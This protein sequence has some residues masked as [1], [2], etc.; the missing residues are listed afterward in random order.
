M[1]NP[2][3]EFKY[4]LPKNVRRMIN[5][6]LWGIEEPAEF[7]KDIPF[8]HFY[9]QKGRSPES[10]VEKEFDPLLRR[11][12]D[13]I[14]SENSDSQSLGE[15]LLAM[16]DYFSAHDYNR[17]MKSRAV[18][19]TFKER[20]ESYSAQVA[21]RPG[22]HPVQELPT[23]FDVTESLRWL[24]R[25]LIILNVPV[26]RTA[27]THSTAAAFCGIPC[28]IAK[29]RHKTPMVLTEH[30]VYM[31]EQNLFLSRF[32]SLL[33]SKRFLLNL[34]NAVSRANYWFADVV[35]PVCRYN[36]RWELAH[37]TDPAKI[38]VIYNGVDAAT[39]SPAPRPAGP[40]HVIATARIDP[41]KD[42]ETF[43]RVAATV[44][45]S[46]PTVR[47]TI[48]GSIADREY[49]EKCLRLRSELRLDDVVA[50]GSHTSDVVSAY[51]ESDIVAL[52]SVSEAFPYSVIE[53]MACGKPVIAS[54]VGGVR[55]ALDEGGI[56]VK[57]RDVEGFASGI[58]AL[59]DDRPRRE[60]MGKAARE[61]VVRRFTL[62]R[63]I[64]GYRNLYERLAGQAA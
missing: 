12:L 36:T 13:N 26:P 20:M 8:A 47:Y 1:M 42:I 55:E 58:R 9:R 64:S 59:L 57:P 21:A 30:G 41:L 14:N 46:H 2:H 25:F 51:R 38:E 43:L 50:M 45:T 39:F 52:T 31:R 37:G 34:I 44:R 22:M 62:E 53:A 7:I 28:I 15:T 35:A 19:R 16:Q 33:F 49:Y 24:Y 60:E 54:D 29:L 5:V 23:L 61:I 3:I 4:E 17:T 27:L 11:F 48:Y 56:A 40:P 10:V 18:W 63:S 32:R 6:P